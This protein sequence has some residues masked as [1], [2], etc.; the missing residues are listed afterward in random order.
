MGLSSTVSCNIIYWAL[1]KNAL[2]DQHC[3]DIFYEYLQSQLCN[4]KVKVCVSMAELCDFPDL[5]YLLGG[6]IYPIRE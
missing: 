1:S 3:T 2:I 5:E 6:K 4:G